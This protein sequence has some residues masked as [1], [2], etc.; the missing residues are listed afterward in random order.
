MYLGGN[1]VSGTKLSTMRL[2]LDL[3]SGVRWAGMILMCLLRRPPKALQRLHSGRLWCQ[4][5]MTSLATTVVRFWQCRTWQWGRAVNKHGERQHGLCSNEDSDGLKGKRIVLGC[6]PELRVDQLDKLGQLTLKQAC[7]LTK[8][9]HQ[10][11]SLTVQDADLWDNLMV[12]VDSVA[13]WNWTGA[14]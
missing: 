2:A 11:L 4:L 14:A 3:A 1:V 13:G 7:I 12:M 10:D 5:S 8:L 6:L 9:G